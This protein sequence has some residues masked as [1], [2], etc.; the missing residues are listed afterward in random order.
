MK[1]GIQS[2]A[3]GPILQVSK[4]WHVF[5][6]FELEVLIILLTISHF[7]GCLWFAIGARN[8]NESNVVQVSMSNHARTRIA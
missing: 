2:D 8:T 1:R 4:A 5:T 3:L 6:H 7:T